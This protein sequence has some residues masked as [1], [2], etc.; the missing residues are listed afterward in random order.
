[1]PFLAQIGVEVMMRFYGISEDEAAERYKSTT[2]LPYE[3]QIKLN[4]PDH[5]NNDEAIEV[6]EKM[7]IDRIFEQELFPES[8]VALKALHQKGFILFVS[9][10]TFQSIIIE[11]FNRLNMSSYFTEIL[12]Y[13]PGFEK[14]PHHFKHVCESHE[15]SLDE[16]VFIGDS[17]KDYER[18]KG[19]TQFVAL[20]GMFTKADFEAAGHQGH[21]IENLV[22]LNAI[23]DLIRE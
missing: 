4:F 12:G 16:V 2:G 18:S 13:R 21:V 5:E 23:L 3:H 20:E 11:Y 14:G 6:F 7:K 9:S 19:Y 10:S 15:I 17:I 8:E 1:M 22:K